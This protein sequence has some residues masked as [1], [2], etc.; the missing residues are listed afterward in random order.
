MYKKKKK[1]HPWRRR[2]IY[3]IWVL[4]IPHIWSGLQDTWKYMF[5]AKGWIRNKPIID[6]GAVLASVFLPRHTTNPAWRCIRTSSAVFS[7]NKN[8]NKKKGITPTKTKQPIPL[9]K[10]A[11]LLRPPPEKNQYRRCGGSSDPQERI[12][13]HAGEPR[14]LVHRERTVYFI[15]RPMKTTHLMK[16]ETLLIRLI[17]LD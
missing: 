17:R 7:S 9:P 16:R 1:S 14:Y 12:R 4:H 10:V 3:T 5:R 6:W 15:W 13:Y 8:H 2:V 11:G